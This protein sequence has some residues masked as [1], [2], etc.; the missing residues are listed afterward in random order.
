MEKIWLKSYDPGV[1]STINPDQYSSLVQMFEESFK[2]FAEKPCY[3]NLG[4]ML[5]FQQTDELSQAFAG[6]LAAGH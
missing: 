3:T 6:Y 1:P 5:S 4:V 2:R